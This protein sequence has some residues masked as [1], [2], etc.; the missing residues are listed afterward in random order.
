MLFKE[1]NKLK[2]IKIVIRYLKKEY[3]IYLF[4]NIFSLF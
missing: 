3:L 4:F 2:H 1:G